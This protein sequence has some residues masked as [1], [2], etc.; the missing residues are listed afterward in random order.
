MTTP[1]Q[2][3]YRKITYKTDPRI[4][5]KLPKDIHQELLVWAELNARSKSDEIIARLI[6]TLQN[7]EEFMAKDRLMRLI[8]SKKLAYRK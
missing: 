2:K 8:S 1:K 6:A 7:N 3:H 5:I 4:C